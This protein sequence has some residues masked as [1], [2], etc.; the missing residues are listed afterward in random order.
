MGLD[1]AGMKKFV[2]SNGEYN[3]K[4]EHGSSLRSSVGRNGYLYQPYLLKSSALSCAHLVCHCDFECL[5]ALSSR[6]MVTALATN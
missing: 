4:D 6:G 5:I 3:P 2:R 1:K